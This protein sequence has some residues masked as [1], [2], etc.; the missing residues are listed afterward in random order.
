[1]T[2]VLVAGATGLVGSNLVKAC[3]EQG[4]EVRALVRPSALADSAKMAPLRSSGAVICVGS[5]E[6]FPS[7][8]K[9][10]AGMEAVISAVGAAQIAQQTELIKAAKQTSIKRFIPSDYGLDPKVAGKGSCVLFDQKAL[11]HQA[12]K[13]S[14][15]N[16]TFVHAN[17]LFEYWAYSLGQLGLPSPPEEVQLYA[18]GTVKAALVSVSDV[19]KVTATTVDDPRTQNKELFITANILSQEELIR[20]WEE[21]SGKRV[22]RIPVSFEDL[23]QIIAASTTPATFM[24]LIIAQLVRSVWVRGDAIKRREGV[25]DAA[26]LYTDIQFTSIKEA[27]SQLV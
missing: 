9:A 17:G 26:E 20:L 8:V 19:A 2:K 12:V 15:L 21:I 14:G 10:C 11:I 22:K 4:K 7:L 1:M 18:Q 16:Y 27:L 3:K 5:L 23:E 24:N 13:E 6:D 25:L